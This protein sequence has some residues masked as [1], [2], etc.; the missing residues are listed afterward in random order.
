MCVGYTLAFLINQF[1]TL[2]AAG[3]FAAGFVP[4]AIAILVMIFVVILI[5]RKIRAH[6]DEKYAL[7]AN[8]AAHA[9]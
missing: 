7:H 8:A 9:A 6:F 1:G 2:I 3:H 5:S 4:G